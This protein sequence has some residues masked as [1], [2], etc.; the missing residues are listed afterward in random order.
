MRRISRL[1]AIIVSAVLLFS[2]SA[3]AHI[4]MNN[5]AENSFTADIAQ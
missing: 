1:T 2:F 4:S 5:D 3:A